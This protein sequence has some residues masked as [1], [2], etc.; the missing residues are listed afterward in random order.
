VSDLNSLH[1]I[2]LWEP[3]LQD[4]ALLL[5]LYALT[6]WKLPHFLTTLLWEDNSKDRREYNLLI[7]NFLALSIVFSKQCE[8]NKHFISGWIL[9]FESVRM[10]SERKEDDTESH[11]AL[12]V[13]ADGRFSKDNEL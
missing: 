7:S 1:Y 12:L 9:F 8:L 10:G 4:P 2:L 13:T 5:S 11:F 6:Y 3:D